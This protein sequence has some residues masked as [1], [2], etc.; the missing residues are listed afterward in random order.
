MPDANFAELVRNFEKAW[1]P[2]LEYMDRWEFRWSVRPLGEV[3][4][5]MLRLD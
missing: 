1:D 4:L 2:L 5:S 3:L